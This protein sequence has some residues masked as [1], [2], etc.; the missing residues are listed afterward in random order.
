MS[1]ADS[2]LPDERATAAQPAPTIGPRLYLRLIVL[3]AV[4]G[5][6]AA[7]IA[8]AFLALVHLAEHW[9]W[10]DLPAALGAAAPPWYLVLGLP[11][12]GATVVLAARLLLPGD[13]GHPATGGLSMGPT[14]LSHVPGIALA[15]LGSLAFG[16]VLGPEA[17]LIALGCAVGGVVAGLA[18][19]GPREST[20]LT[21]AGAFSAISALF[22]GPL[23]ASFMLIEGGVRLGAALIPSLLPGLVAS[24]VGYLIFIGLGDWGGVSSA[25]LTVPSLPDYHGTSLRDLVVALLVGVVAAVVVT[26]AKQFGATIMARTQRLGVVVPLLLGGLILGALALGVRALGGDS[27]D[28]LFSGQ[29]SLPVLAAETSVG[30]LVILLAAKAIGF[31]VSVGAGFRGGP[32]FP[33]MF[34]GVAVAMIP[35]VLLGM[36]PTLALA[37][38]AAA[39]MAAAVRLLFSP[40]LF[41]ILLVGDAGQDTVSAA[42]LASVAA[43]LTTIALQRK[44]TVDEPT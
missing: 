7:G 22:G 40:V 14:P 34:L 27:Q 43:W 6:P 24:A 15:A 31:A 23:V 41:A 28:E 13:G 42:V 1:P 29:A 21:T 3:G 39:G 37:V 33:P 19:L 17:P 44:G 30:A 8:A 9:L 16:A 10:T 32:V 18:R 4:I 2:N 38:G 35:A 36:S 20:L 5:L 11:V 12:V 25:G 26:A